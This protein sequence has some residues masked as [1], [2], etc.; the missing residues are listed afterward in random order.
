[1]I[2]NVRNVPHTFKTLAMFFSSQKTFFMVYLMFE[3]LQML[4]N[5]FDKTFG[6]KLNAENV[7]NEIT[8][9]F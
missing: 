3:T 7:F 4:A 2:N 6:A 5:D 8:L 9:R 1:M